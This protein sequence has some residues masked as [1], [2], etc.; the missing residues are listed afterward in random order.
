[1]G[2]VLVM[3]TLIVVLNMVRSHWA[4]GHAGHPGQPDR[5]R[6]RR[7]QCTKYTKLLRYLLQLLA[8]AAGALFGLNYSS[9]SAAYLT[10]TSPFWCWCTWCLGGLGNIWGSIIAAVVLYVLPVAP[11]SLLTC[12]CWCMPSM[13]ILVMLATNN[14]QMRGLVGKIIPQ[15]KGGG[16]GWLRNLKREMVVPVPSHSII[17]ERDIDKSPILECKPSGHRFRRPE[18]GGRL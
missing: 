15:T 7:H 9:V 14:P 2:F 16:C 3:I 8:G 6:E 11:G 1:M 4:G 10:L 12:V 17:P 13:L 5:C 18:G